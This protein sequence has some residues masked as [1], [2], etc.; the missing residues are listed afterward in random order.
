MHKEVLKFFRFAE[1]AEGREIMDNTDGL[2]VHIDNQLYLIKIIK[3]HETSPWGYF[4]VYQMQNEQWK[5]IAQPFV[6]ME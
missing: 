6:E 3:E 5:L 1:V 2:V 4:E